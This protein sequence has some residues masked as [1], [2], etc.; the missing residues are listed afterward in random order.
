MSTM[1]L[2]KVLGKRHRLGLVLRHTRQETLDRRSQLRAT[3][4]AK[5]HTGCFAQFNASPSESSFRGNDNAPGRDGLS[6]DPGAAK[7]K[8]GRIIGK[9]HHIDLMCLLKVLVT[10]ENSI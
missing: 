5:S 10:V 8:R 3:V 2:T 6:K 1:P 7:T 9:Q 4:R